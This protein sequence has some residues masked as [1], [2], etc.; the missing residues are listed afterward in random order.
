M[1]LKSDCSGIARNLLYTCE[2]HGT[3][4]MAALG[5]VTMAVD[6]EHQKT[7]SEEVKRH[8]TSCQRCSGLVMSGLLGVAVALLTEL[9][10]DRGEIPADGN[11]TEPLMEFWRSFATDLSAQ[12]YTGGP[13]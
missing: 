6:P 4:A 13:E 7:L 10:A 1:A 2:A 8:V 11:I 9:Y 12:A 5:M 3:E